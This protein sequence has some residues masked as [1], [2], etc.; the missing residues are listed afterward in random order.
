MLVLRCGRNHLEI[1]PLKTVDIQ[2]TTVTVPLRFLGSTFSQNLRWFSNSHIFQKKVQQRL[3]F[4]TLLKKVQLGRGAAGHLLLLLKTIIQ[5]VLGSCTTVWF[6]WITKHDRA[7]LQWI[8]RSAERIYR[9]DC[10][11]IWLLYKSRE[12]NR[13]AS[14]SA[15]PGQKLFKPLPS[16]CYLQ[17]PA[18]AETVSPPRLSLSWTLNGPREPRSIPRIF[19]LIQPHLFFCCN[20]TVYTLFIYH[21]Y[22]KKRLYFSSEFIYF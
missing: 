3:H 9:A 4:L 15:H 11:S 17:K 18:A 6:G 7:K 20:N 14:I 8:I 19:T 13:E 10:P 12:R 22:I 1:N 16:G 21:I 5:S 2:R